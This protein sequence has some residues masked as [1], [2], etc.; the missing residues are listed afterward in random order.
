MKYGFKD[1]TTRNIMERL[2]NLCSKIDKHRSGQE[3][4][5]FFFRYIYF[6]CT[7]AHDKNQFNS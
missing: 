3:V 2:S 6:Y 5:L 1:V 4:F 7:N